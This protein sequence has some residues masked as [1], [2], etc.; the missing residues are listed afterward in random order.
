MCMYLYS[1]PLLNDSYNDR[2]GNNI[3]PSNFLKLTSHEVTFAAEQIDY[4]YHVINVHPFCV[5]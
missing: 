5:T 3:L 4:N 2:A 1:F